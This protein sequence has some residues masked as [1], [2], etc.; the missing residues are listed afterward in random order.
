MRPKDS[1]T[2]MVEVIW[3]LSVVPCRSE[4]N[5]GRGVL[6][7]RTYIEET[8]RRSRTSYSTLQ[9]ALYYLILI[10]PFVPMSDFTQ[11]Q[12]MDCPASRALMCGR[13]MF[14]AALILASKYLQDRNYSAKAWSKMSG[15]KANEINTNERTFLGKVN[16]KLHIPEAIFKRWT[17]IVL[18]YTPN[19]PPPSPGQSMAIPTWKSIVPILTPELDLV[20]MPVDKVQTISAAT[21]A[22]Y[23]FASPSATPTPTKSTLNPMSFTSTSHENTP[24]PL[25]VLPR[26]LEPKPDLAPPTPALAGMGPLP[27]PLMTPSSVASSTPAVSVCGSRRPSMCSAMAVA[28]KTTFNRCAFDT[29]PGAVLSHFTSRRPS[30]TSSASSRSS[31]ESMIS[32]RSRSSRASSISSISTVSTN[33][34]L[35]PYRP[36]LARQATCRN[37][38]LPPPASWKESKG[39]VDGTA[40]KPI[41]IDDDVQMASSP[42]TIDFTV[43]E[44]VMLR[45]HKHSKSASRPHTPSTAMAAQKGR[46]RGR[47]HG[48]RHSDLQDEIRFQLA[49]HDDDAMDLD[50][51]HAVSPSPAAEYAS[52]M[53]SGS[54]AVN[55]ST[56]DVQPPASLSRRESYRM[57]VPREASSKRTCCSTSAMSISPSPALLCGEVA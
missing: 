27:T 3:P 39:I 41:I 52:R 22:N 55:G 11:E 2:Q 34:S 42:E 30:I 26:F 14:L 49:E 51:D 20:P 40:G 13:R 8:L 36:C 33:A 5:S 50:A 43:S 48:N 6:P 7:L 35:A 18:R 28:Q 12:K 21:A 25:T 29:Y 1:A 46:K 4:G 44:K 17:D 9:V 32:D 47:S 54:L 37:V 23:S 24:T 57:P 15:L 31:P 38:R 19:T 45:P 10:R 56:K 16:W 53:L